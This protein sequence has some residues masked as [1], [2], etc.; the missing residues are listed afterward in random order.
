MEA[1]ANLVGQVHDYRSR[2]TVIERRAKE[3]ELERAKAAGE[4]PAR[5]VAS[6]AEWGR[7]AREGTIRVRVPCAGPGHGSHFAVHRVRQRGSG[8]GRS[9]DGFETRERAAAAGLSPQELEALAEA[10]TRTHAR[11]WA[12]MRSACEADVGFRESMEGRD[13]NDELTDEE[14]IDECRSHVLDIDAPS[15]RAGL[16]R[17][18]ELQ[19]VGAGMNGATTD[20]QRVA[21]ALASSPAALFDEMVRALGREKATRAIDNGVL[22]LD[23]TLFDLRT[24]TESES[25]SDEG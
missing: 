20:E 22:C 10:Y 6:R 25:E 5:L 3:A 1:N 21:F 13:P 9:G 2:L 14:R 18:A 23:E 7:M 19:A 15:A 11:T 4:P 16:T 8:L 17:A 24:E 12:A